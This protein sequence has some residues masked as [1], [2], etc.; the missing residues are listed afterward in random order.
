MIVLVPCRGIFRLN[1]L[2]VG[3]GSVLKSGTRLLS[4]ASMEPN[5]M[6]LEHT[7]VMSGECLDEGMMWQGWPCK[8]QGPIKEHRLELMRRF[9]EMSKARKVQR[10]KLKNDEDRALAICFSK[11][12]A[13]CSDDVDASLIESHHGQ[14]AMK[15]RVAQN[16]LSGFSL[17]RTEVQPGSRAETSPLLIG[18]GIGS[19]RPSGQME[20]H[21]P[22]GSV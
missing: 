7:L 4:G 17:S 19:H 20:L 22:Y 14:A 12:C 18:S 21:G 11:Y 6:M 13:P 5:S 9:L 1:P 10:E 3:S 8:F 15:V 16:P 2:V